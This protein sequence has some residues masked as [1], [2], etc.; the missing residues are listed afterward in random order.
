MKA[1][2]TSFVY[3][4]FLPSLN[5]IKVG[6]GED[7]ER[8]MYSYTRDYGI[9][10][11]FETLKTWEM[12]SAGIAS[13]VES[14]CHETLVK[15]GI[16]RLNISN[17]DVN[18]NEIFHLREVS[19]S[20][21]IEII[22]EEI[23]QYFSYL[24]ASLDG[25]SFASEERSTKKKEEIQKSKQEA[26]EAAIKD[27]ENDLKSNYERYYGSF[28]REAKKAD[29]YWRSMP[30][31]QR[32]SL[33]AMFKGWKSRDE[34]FLKWEGLHK[35]LVNVSPILKSARVA[36]SYY[37]DI[38]NKYPIELISKAERSAGVSL[39]SPFGGYQLP[40]VYPSVVALCNDEVIRVDNAVYEVMMCTQIATGL[41][42][43]CYELIKDHKVLQ[44]LVGFA[45]QYPPPELKQN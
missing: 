8:R 2:T 20:D 12:P 6:Y 29:H 4:Y 34:A 39:Y 44:D 1:R 33:T 9:A 26:I 45:R 28:I 36:K 23:D 41:G 37:L 18:A 19:Y 22:V 35:C 17:N 16:E 43:G 11:D 14:I 24:R 40:I 31:T 32:N 7:P 25:K 42:E 5:A 3:S 10:A 15:I 27:I 21:A 38:T 13:N 30:F